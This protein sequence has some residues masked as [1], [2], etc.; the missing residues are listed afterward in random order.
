MCTWPQDE[1]LQAVGADHSRVRWWRR[2]TCAPRLIDT[3]GFGGG[4]GSVRTVPPVRRS[5][6]RWLLSVVTVRSQFRDLS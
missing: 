2:C 5:T 6:G 4:S 3:F 1:W